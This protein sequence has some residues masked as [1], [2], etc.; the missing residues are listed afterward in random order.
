MRATAPLSR[1]AGDP[2]GGA[3]GDG[4]LGGLGG[5]GDRREL[6]KLWNLRELGGGHGMKVRINGESKVGGR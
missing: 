3:W 1:G 6:R 4:R 5:L 2:R